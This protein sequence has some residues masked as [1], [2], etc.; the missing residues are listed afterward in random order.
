MRVILQKTTAAKIHEK[1]Q[2]FDLSLIKRDL[3]ILNQVYFS[4][5]KPIFY[6]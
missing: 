4:G 2:T 6:I 1:N 5:V 3:F